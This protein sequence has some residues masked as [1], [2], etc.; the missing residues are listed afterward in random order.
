MCS[1]D[2][3]LWKK[4][5]NKIELL[6][7]MVLPVHSYFTL[8]QSFIPD[9]GV[10]RRMAVSC[11]ASISKDSNGRNVGKL[12]HQIEN[13]VVGFPLVH[14]QSG[15]VLMSGKVIFDAVWLQYVQTDHDRYFAFVLQIETKPIRIQR[16][17]CNSRLGLTSRKFQESRSG[18]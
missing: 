3:L 16:N 14:E 5:K 10:K 7:V 2:S 9:R 15:I 8:L 4:E 1:E 6:L 12:A 17:N 13:N 18:S 11:K